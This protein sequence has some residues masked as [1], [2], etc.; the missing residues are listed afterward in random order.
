MAKRHETYWLDDG[1]VILAVND[2]LFRVHKSL[3]ARHSTFFDGLFK[4]PT[5]Y[6]QA[7]EAEESPD[8]YEG[9]PIVKMVDDEVEGVEQ[10]LRLLYDPWSVSVYQIYYNK[11]N[12]L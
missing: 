8:H 12:F 5:P 7:G 6:L 11:F 9:L 2:T 1:N 4:V 10:V 3:L